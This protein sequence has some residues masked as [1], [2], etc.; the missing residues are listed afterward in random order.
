M[1]RPIFDSR[2]PLYKTPF[3][4]VPC[5]RHITLT[6]YPPVEENFTGGALIL[7]LEF[8]GEIREIPLVPAPAPSA[9]PEVPVSE[10]AAADRTGS[11]VDTG[12]HQGGAAAPEGESTV[13]AEESSAASVPAVF[14]VAYTAPAEPELIWYCFRFTR[15]DGSAAFLG[16]NGL[17]GEGQAACWQQTVYDD[18]LSTP[19]WF[20]RGVTYQIF[21]DRFHRTF[22]PDPAGMLGD[23]IVHQNWEE[24][25]DYLPDEHGEIRNRDFFGGSLMGIEEKLPYL[26]ELGVRTLYLC[27]IFESDSNHRYNTGD[28]DK[29]DPML[30]TE[31]DFTRLCTKAHALGIRVML[32]G[33]FNHTGNNSRYFNVLGAYPSLGAAQSQESPYYPWYNFQ[34]WPHRYDCWWGIHTLPAVNE[35]HPEYIDFIIEGKD[36]VI[37]RWLRAGADAWR[38]DVADELP[39]EFIAR[40]RR[41]MMEEKAESFLLGEVWE[42]GSNKI[43]YSKRRK[44]LL[45]RE[46]HGLMNYPFRVSAMDYLRGG[47]AAAFRDAM[48]TIREN[49]PRPAFYSCMNMLGTH[50][51]PRILTLLGTFPKEA[52]HTRTERAHYRMSPEEYHRGCRLLQTGAIIL[53]A[54]P[55]SPTIFYGDEAGME[56]YEDPFNR[57]TF[58][59]GHEDRVLQRRFA[60][61]GSLRNNRLSLQKGDIRWLYAQGHG[62]AFAR[63]L[64]DEVTIAATNAGDEPVFMTFDWSADLATDALTGQQFLTVSGKI[65]ICL[66]PLDG[67]LLV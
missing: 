51:N 14:T 29:I 3:G 57:G 21:P 27:P 62:L 16:K 47:D 38:L 7:N 36:A 15:R 44:Y 60:L 22:I 53:Y 9:S 28:Y 37:R 11:N 18:Q 12:G 65:T 67:V 64:G 40:I 48:E 13:P 39:D 45:G 46:T 42:D 17:C 6:L 43:A 19:E 54:F 23:R 49:Y 63:T 41:V 59:W 56:G 58:P 34:E 24:L 52:P 32:D 1:E 10:T 55:G 8:A 50:D 66:P 33:V 4:A 25:M 2:S 26:K 61:L 35:S 5:G 20:G 30:G 31:E